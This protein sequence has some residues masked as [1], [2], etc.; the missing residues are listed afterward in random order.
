MV[1]I[2]RQTRVAAPPSRDAIPPRLRRRGGT[3]RQVLAMTVIG[4]LLLAIFA[5]ADLLSWLDRMGGGPL[6]APLQHAAA[7]WHGAMA[8]LYLDRPQKLLRS[9]MHRMLD[10]RWPDQ[11]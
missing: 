1:A 4:T 3:A 7:Q 5:S 6:L 10:W 8:R 9:T 11:D 2:E